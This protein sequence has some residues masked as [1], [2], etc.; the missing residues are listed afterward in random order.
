MTARR[1]AILIVGVLVDEQLHRDRE[2]FLRPNHSFADGDLA[3]HEQAGSIVAADDV[4]QLGTVR[5]FRLPRCIT[6]SL[7]AKYA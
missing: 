5:T 6:P 1:A 4:A 2:D 7:S 3:A